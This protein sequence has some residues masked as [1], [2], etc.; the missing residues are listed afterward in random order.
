MMLGHLRANLWLLGLTLVLCSVI[1]PL[2]LFGIGQTAFHDRAEGSLIVGADGKAIGSSLIA[3][4]FKADEYF[5]PRPSAASYNAAASGASNF[6]ASNPLLRDR[7]AR[8]LGTMARYRGT[9]QAVGPD[10][11]KWFQQQPPD[12]VKRWASEHPALAQ[13]WVKDNPEA[14]AAW[15]QKD[16]AAVKDKPDEA[17][18]AFFASFAKKHP[19]AWP[20][21]NDVKGPDGKTT[22]QAQ[23]AR[24]GSDVQSY[25]FDVWLQAHP[26]ADIE[27]V[28]A[29][30]VT[31]SGS[32]LDPDITLKGA[33]YQLDRVAGAWAKR[34]GRGEADIRKEV[35][36]LLQEKGFAP[37]GGLAGV[38]LVNV[39][40]INLALHDRYGS[41]AQASK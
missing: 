3:Q 18:T 36:S 21:V 4:P 31:T 11:E 17:A 2:I 39:L 9:H 5:Q 1:Y 35:E 15:L 6:S 32:G 40:E 37:L 14:V 20:T 19:G 7:V 33:L 38:K 10:V 26:S 24:D 28:P 8:S 13:Q 25:L 29:D 12:F 16:V 22:K 34:T 23:P 41:S 27:E 30:L